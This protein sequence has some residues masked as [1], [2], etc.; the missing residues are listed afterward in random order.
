[1]AS[2]SGYVESREQDNNNTGFF[3][4]SIGGWGDYNVWEDIAYSQ[5]VVLNASI[6]F[7]DWENISPFSVTSTTGLDNSNRHKVWGVDFNDDGWGF[8]LESNGGG[9]CRLWSVRTYY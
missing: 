7:R 5:S 4:W 3:K 6:T 2:M 8:F 9:D 1:M